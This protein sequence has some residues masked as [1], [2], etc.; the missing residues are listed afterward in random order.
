[1]Y[2]N[3]TDPPRVFGAGHAGAGVPTAQARWFLA[4]GATGSFFDLYYLI[5]NPAPQAARV[6][7]SYL[8]PAG[9]PVVKST[10]RRREP[11]DNL[12]GREDRVSSTHR[13]PRS[14]NPSTGSASS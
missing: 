12:G 5:A 1:M 9:A 6:R 13:C 10:R 2:M 3:T 14:S 8:L 11:P 4:E 7:V